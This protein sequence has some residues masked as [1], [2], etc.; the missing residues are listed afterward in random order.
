MNRF[1]QLFRGKEFASQ[2]I[3]TLRKHFASIIHL[4]AVLITVTLNA[5]YDDGMF[6]YLQYESTGNTSRLIFTNTSA[7]AVSTT[8]ITE[9][10]GYTYSPT[11][12]VPLV[13][14]GRVVNNLTQSLVNVLSADNRVEYLVNDRL[15]DYVSFE[16]VA[17]I[18]TGL[19]ILSVKDVNRVY[20][21]NKGIKV[22]FAYQTTGSVLGLSVLSGFWIETYLKGVKQDRS[23]TQGSGE[24][25]KLLN[26]NLLNVAGGLSEVSFTTKKPF[27]EVR[28]GNSSIDVTALGGMKF[29]YAFVGDNEEKIAAEA[30]LGYTDYQHAEGEYYA[31]VLGIGTWKTCESLVD[32]N[33]DNGPI[34]ELLT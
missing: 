13:G 21:N 31:N 15:D 2:R 11:C 24:S 18:N 25:F 20:Y 1:Y 7:L 6:S 23:T 22:G 26:L 10:G 8:P 12:R 30:P 14:E 32:D 17:D 9:Y 33:P 5:C 16:G 27:D 29:Y 28:I 34:C 3:Q 19:P 4:L